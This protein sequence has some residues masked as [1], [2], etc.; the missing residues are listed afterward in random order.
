MAVTE[1]AGCGRAYAG[2]PFAPVHPAPATPRDHLRAAL[3]AVH[4]VAVVGMALPSP[5]GL[6]EAKMKRADVAAQVESWT[7]TLGAVG[8]PEDAAVWLMFEGGRALEKVE[9]RAERTF[10]P[11]ARYAGV[12]QSWRMFS[13]SAPNGSRVE[14]WVREGGT[15]RPVYVALDPDAR[16]RASLWE[17]GRVRGAVKVLGGKR[18]VE[19]WEAF[20]KSAARRAAVDFPNADAFR[21]QR[22]PLRYPPPEGIAAK[23][24]VAGA[25]VGMVEVDLMALRGGP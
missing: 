25:P 19:R 7:A 22:V 8:V 17:D 1:P 15:W 2:I 10:A 13:S 14:M 16:W 6:T 24:R 20:A 5:E 9:D 23:G 3:V 11:Y 21:L 18:F 12:R 4:M